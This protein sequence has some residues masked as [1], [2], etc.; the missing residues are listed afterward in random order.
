MIKHRLSLLLTSCILACGLGG[1]TL[2]SL[3]PLSI[4]AT[5]TES[6]AQVRLALAIGGY[7][8][9]QDID[10]SSPPFNSSR[11]TF[12][13]SG[14]T[15]PPSNRVLNGYLLDGKVFDGVICN[16]LP[17]SN[18]EVNA[19][20]D[21]PG[22]NLV[23][24]YRA[25]RLIQ[26]SELLSTTLPTEALG[27]LRQ[28]L[29]KAD[30]TPAGEENPGYGVGLKRQA[31]L[32]RT[33]AQF[34]WNSA[35]AGNLSDAKR[36]TEHVLN[37]LYGSAD[38]RYGD[39][40]GD[41]R[42]QNPGDGYGLLVYR[43][44]MGQVLT[45]AAGSSDS[46]T[47]IQDR[48]AEAQLALN[49]IGNSEDGQWAQL[50]IGHAEN[51]LA[52][53]SATDAKSA[54][55]LLIGVADVILN[56]EEVND[57]GK[58]DPEEG[59]A[60]VAYQR[61]QYA[62]E[63]QVAEG[64]VRYAD[65]DDGENNALRIKL[66]GLTA[67]ETDEAYYVYLL[68]DD[69]ERMMFGPI[70]APDGNIDTTIDGPLQLNLAGRHNGLV[71]TVGKEIAYDML[72][73]EPWGYIR[74]MLA[75]VSGTPDEKGYAVG[76]KEQSQLL[77]THA[78]NA[79]NAA[80]DTS[81]SN[82]K[83]L[84]QA[85]THTE[86]VLNILYGENDPRYGDQDGDG[87]TFNPGDKFGVLG[88]RLQMLQVI[89]QAEQSSDLTQN[90]LARLTEVRN[91]L[92]N[93]GSGESLQAQL[94][95]SPQDT[96]WAT[97]L[98]DRAGSVLS[99]SSVADAETLTSQMRLF[100]DL[101][102][103]G[104]DN[105]ENGKVDPVIGEAGA[106]T[107]YRSAQRAV[108]YMPSEANVVEPTA[109]PTPTST[110]VTPTPTATP[111]PN[112]PTPTPTSTIAPSGDGD[113]YEDD[114]Q[115]SIARTIPTDG[116]VQTHTFHQEGDT[117]SDIDWVRFDANSG[118][119]YIIEVSIPEGSP[120]DVAA[121][122]YPACDAAAADAQDFRFA[123]GV[124]IDFTA[125]ETG[126]VY[127]KFFNSK[128]GVSGDDVRYELSVRSL[129]TTATKPG[130]LI[131]V[132]GAIKD[133]D[134]VQPNIYHVTDEVR[135]LFIDKGATDDDIYYIAPDLSRTGVDASASRANLEAAITQWADERAES[136]QSL[137][138]YLMDH[139]GDD[140]F[141]LD[142]RRGEW[143]MPDQL[144]GWLSKLET[145]RPTLNINVIYEACESGSFI[146]GD[147]SIS[148][149]GRVVMVSTDD[150]NL[151]WA[152]DDGAIFSDH[153][154]DGLRRGESL[155]SSFKN[156]R[157]AAQIA[158]PNQQPWI[159]ADGDG[160]GTD[161]ASQTVAAQRGFA[162]AGTFPDEI[163]PPFIAEVQK[164]EPD[165]EGRGVLRAQVRDD[166]SVDR[167]WAVVYPP[168]YDAPTEG[169]ELVQ[170]ALPT[171]VLLDQGNDW[172]GARYDGFREPG[173]Y[174]VV[175]FADDNQDVNARPFS[176]E[177]QVGSGNIYLP[178]VMK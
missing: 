87:S 170:E 105:D 136:A 75:N 126:P 106:A 60:V 68:Q 147:K 31:A 125:S 28:L 95:N 12:T 3:K 128:S 49:N 150:V 110:V 124:R 130:L 143:I 44:K 59:G 83:R 67:P 62:A 112:V 21:F 118:E 4:P 88:Y 141:Y 149:P 54:A 174:R 56:G 156:A 92:A 137:T 164:I 46:T 32:L 148:K 127:L 120:A 16:A 173:T 39:Q 98:I 162:F 155:Y 9:P 97:E 35:D 8:S 166:V 145:L 57:N 134:P 119:A 159:D 47:N 91:A 142:K 169:E 38:A 99:A 100:A 36:H 30:D 10:P 34:A 24:S 33:H 175:F 107:A 84:K 93:I 109:T 25:M 133:N 78:K 171:A 103:Q 42:T 76:L 22:R 111:D 172:Y 53:S 161:D 13:L 114:N 69:D 74:T 51:L 131:V 102:S 140:I 65:N 50:L 15:P 115:C 94:L 5:Q 23:A 77:A 64:S 139:G 108:D 157:I 17:V 177:V 1:I 72:P 18:G 85:K 132:A 116:L 79:Y 167:V 66:S 96:G 86:H 165:E 71:V 144:D 80:S 41:S 135:Q 45:Q 40:D 55:D 19:S 58:I 26:E 29:A 81:L 11:I 63:Y 158:H 113:Q 52:A 27:Y 90:M 89:D 61:A 152:S 70:S 73:S 117:G 178:V 153:L 20:Y 138:L 14:I 121:E 7:A 6:P 151:A 2:L 82:A 104:E 168:S 176:V 122:R 123:P 43:T 48:A 163:W 154:L 160:N 37:I 146:S 129:Q 101:I